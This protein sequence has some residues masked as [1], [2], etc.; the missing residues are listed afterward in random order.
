VHFCEAKG[1]NFLMGIMNVLPPALLKTKLFE[2]LDQSELKALVNK[3]TIKNFAVGENLI[4]E[5]DTGEEFYCVTSGSVQI[6][7]S[8]QLGSAIMLK[9]LNEGDVLGELILLK[10]NKRSATA[11]ATKNVDTIVWKYEQCLDL[12][13][14]NPQLGYK[15]MRNL[16]LMVGDRLTDMNALYKNK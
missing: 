10:K 9:V 6:S 2:G 1:Y 3:G 4:T 12:F 7:T 11:V 16:A 14:I 5:G 15:I 8:N 13:S